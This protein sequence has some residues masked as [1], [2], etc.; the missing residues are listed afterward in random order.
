M[1]FEVERK[2][3]IVNVIKEK[4]EKTELSQEVILD[5]QQ[6]INRCN[7]T[8]NHIL[9]S[10]YNFTGRLACSGV[11]AFLG[12]FWSADRVSTGK[13]MGVKNAAFILGSAF[14][15]GLIGYFI[16]GGR[17]FGNLPDLCL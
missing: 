5:L 2:R 9:R 14:F 12:V 11:F 6:E 13:K 8:M 10:Q 1:D 17:K 15:G 3:E 7:H 4:N 16:V